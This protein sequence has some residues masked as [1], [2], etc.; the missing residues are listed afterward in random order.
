MRQVINNTSNM[1]KI[2]NRI[3]L[4]AVMALVCSY[5]YSQTEENQYPKH[6]LSAHGG[7]AVVT[8][9]IDLGDKTYS[10]KNGT[11]WRL[12]YDRIYK[13][14]I[15]FGIS[16]Q[17]FYTDFDS[18]YSR[19]GEAFYIG[20]SIVAYRN[21]GTKWM[22]SA[23]FGLGYSCFYDSMETQH[24]TALDGKLGIDYKLTKSFAIGVSAGY[25]LNFM[26]KPKNY[27]NTEDF[28][29]IKRFYL[30]PSLKL[31]L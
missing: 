7:W 27:I 20:P 22:Y 1:R 13:S 16:A 26:R 28:Y 12:E 6:I 30:M 9:K 21:L 14:G 10:T 24:G 19:Y 3:L 2:F 25:N 11:D 31:Y 15:G 8:S 23:S 5:G 17:F 4:S 18:S 29:G